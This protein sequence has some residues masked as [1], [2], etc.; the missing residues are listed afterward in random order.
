MD[1]YGA[2]DLAKLK[3]SYPIPHTRRELM[4]RHEALRDGEAFV[5]LDKKIPAIRGSG[6]YY[7]VTPIP[8]FNIGLGA[9]FGT[10]TTLKDVSPTPLPQLAINQLRPGS[11]LLIEANGTYTCATGITYQFAVIYGAVAGAA[12]GVNLSASSVITSGTSPTAWPWYLYYNGVVTSSGAAGSITGQGYLMFGTA[13]TTFSVVPMPIT[14]AARTVAID[15]TVSKLLG[16]GCAIGTSG[17]GNTV[18]CYNVAALL[19]N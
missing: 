6:D 8:P 1:T 10:F 4:R 11:G 12:G 13:L 7:L 15:T 18:Q 19:L 3:D 2:H 17:A 16:I 14:A 9:S 5:D